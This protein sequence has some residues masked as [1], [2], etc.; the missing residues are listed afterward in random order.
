MTRRRYPLIVRLARIDRELDTT[1][2]M[3]AVIGDDTLDNMA[4][5]DAAGQRTLILAGIVAAL[6]MG[7]GVDG[8][9]VQAWLTEMDPAGDGADAD[10]LGGKIVQQI[11]VLFG[12][13]AGEG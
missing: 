9:L 6:L 7:H 8:G 2:Q 4:A 13:M 12:P 1:A 10:L 3:L 5:V 11:I